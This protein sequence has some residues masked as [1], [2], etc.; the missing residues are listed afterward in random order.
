[1]LNRKKSLYIILILAVLVLIIGL[2]SVVS[3][4]SDDVGNSND[5]KGKIWIHTYGHGSTFKSAEWDSP[6]GIKFRD[7]AWLLSFVAYYDISF[8][9]DKGFSVGGESG[10]MGSG[11]SDRGL[12]I[13]DRATKMEIYVGV[14]Q[15]VRTA[16]LSY[17]SGVIPATDA[18]MAFDGT[19]G[20][21][22]FHL[23]T[24]NGFDSGYIQMNNDK[25]PDKRPKE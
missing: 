13:P 21:R 9:D 22:N 16:A 15:Y 3:A 18:A 23:K 12:D 7:K 11:S 19:I 1:M 20:T 8:Y 6:N 17:Y 4:D 14:S 2:I 10:S 5:S 25:N 24:K